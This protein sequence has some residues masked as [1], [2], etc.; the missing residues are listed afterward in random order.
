ME[1]ALKDQ[2]VH[3]L[4]AQITRLQQKKRRKVPSPNK[5]FIQLSKILGGGKEFEDIEE[6]VLDEIEVAVEV[7]DSSEEEEEEEEEE[8]NPPDL[9]TVCTRSGRQIR[10]PEALAN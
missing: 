8:A 1:L 6:P 2:K 7:V 9:S 10:R 5:R 3:A 4:E